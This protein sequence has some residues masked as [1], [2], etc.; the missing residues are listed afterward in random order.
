M[1]PQRIRELV[2]LIARSNI[3]YGEDGDLSDN[4]GEFIR[5]IGG[6]QGEE[7]CAA[8]AGYCYRRAA[9]KLNL[10]P[11]VVM[12][13]TYRK[14]RPELGAKRLTKNLSAI[15]TK[16][17]DLTLAQ[18]GDLVCYHRSKFGPLDWRGHVAVFERR[19]SDTAFLTIDGNVGKF[20]AKVKRRY[21]DLNVCNLYTFAS[22]G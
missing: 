9:Q 19:L 12:E 5:L 1:D 15:G 6:V 8:F 4:C 20:P 10:D 11:L 2:L 18:P 16:F 13:W 22:L 3:G 17:T 7:W 21:R 14:G